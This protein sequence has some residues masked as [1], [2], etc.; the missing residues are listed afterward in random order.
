LSLRAVAGQGE[1]NGVVELDGGVAAVQARR[2]QTL[3]GERE[4]DGEVVPVGVL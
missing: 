4:N 2:R 3:T 1:A